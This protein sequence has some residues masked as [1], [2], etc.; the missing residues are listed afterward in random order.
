MKT[1][2]SSRLLLKNLSYIALAICIFLV[3]CSSE[4][5]SFEDTNVVDDSTNEEITSCTNPEDFIFKEKEGL[6]VVEFEKAA[7]SGDW[8]QKDNEPD[9]S[10]QGFMVWT[11]DQNLQNPGEGLTIFKIEIETPGTYQFL[12]NSAVTIGDE[13]TEHNDTWLRFNDANDFF[14]QKNNSIVYPSGSGKTPN[15]NG[16]SK[17][18]WFKIYRSGNNLG[19]KWQSKTSDNDGHDIFVTFDTAG[20]YNMEVSARSSGHAIDKFILFT[21][22]YSLAQATAETA[23]SEIECN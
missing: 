19:F 1:P 7:F 14:G 23:L 6:I 4:S 9:F 2:N 18:G 20:I 22:D 16:S 8:E 17:D 10:G 3:S 11:G 21:E 13:G 12:W 5:S 15:P